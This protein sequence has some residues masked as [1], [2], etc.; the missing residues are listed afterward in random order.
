MDEEFKEEF[1]RWKQGIDYEYACRQCHQS[2]LETHRLDDPGPKD[3]P[4]C[5]SEDIYR[6][7]GSSGFILKGAGW[8]ST[9]YYKFQ[10]YDSLQAQGN[11]VDLYDNEEEMDRVIK[12]EKQEREK[13]KLKR[14]YELEKKHGLR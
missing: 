3:C 7:V 2:W 11:K 9:G 1:E 6:C 13:K 10:A 5:L 8:A 14:R 4:V 12:G